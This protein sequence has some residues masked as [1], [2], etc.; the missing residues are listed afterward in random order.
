MSVKDIQLILV[1]SSAW[2]KSFRGEADRDSL[3]VISSAIEDNCCVITPP[4]V[5]ELLQGAK[6]AKEFQLLKKQL[7]SLIVDKITD[8]DWEKVYELAFLLRRKGF[9][10]PTMDILIASRAVEKKYL[11]LHCDKHFQLIAKYSKLDQLSM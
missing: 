11:L 4:I 10:I 9:A 6:N 7:E 1:D 5:V 3:R 8:L 2:I